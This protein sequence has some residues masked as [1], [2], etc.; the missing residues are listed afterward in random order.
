MV[1][2]QVEISEKDNEKFLSVFEK[3]STSKAKA[4]S[5]CLSKIMELESDDI[6]D[7]FLERKPTKE[8][9]EVGGIKFEN[10]PETMGKNLTLFLQK[11]IKSKIIVKKIT[12]EAQKLTIAEV[13]TQ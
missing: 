2:V 4:I 3:V 1:K 13:Y 6:M 9:I 10:D 12:I 7:L 11:C 5:F 8:I